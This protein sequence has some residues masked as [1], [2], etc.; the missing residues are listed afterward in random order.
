M[1]Y[2]KAEFTRGIQVFCLQVCRHVPLKY[3][4]TQTGTETNKQTV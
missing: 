4:K 2:L 3:N 1:C